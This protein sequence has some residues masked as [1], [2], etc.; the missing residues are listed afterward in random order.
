MEEKSASEVIARLDRIPIWSLSSIFIGILGVGFLFT[1]FDIFDINV[2]FI[3]TALTTFGVTS[4]SSPRIAELLG[5]V[6]LWNL[7]GYVVG[8]LLITPLS[9]RFGR[10]S[11]LVLTMAI[12]GL[13]S[14]YNALSPDYTNYLIARTITGVGVGADLAIVNTY[15]NEVAPIQGRAK[16]TSM[17]FLFA[18]LG[19]FLGLWLGLLLT[20]PPSPFPL[21]LPFALGS[22]GIFTTSGWRI[23]Y[24]IG[25]LLAIIGLALRFELP[26]S[27]RW[28]ISKGRVKEASEIVSRMERMAERKLGSLPPVPQYLE[29]KVATETSY[30]EALK[31]ILGNRVYLR[32]WIVLMLMWFFGYITVYTN[33]AGLTTILSALGYPPPEAGMIAALGV[34]GFIAVPLVLIFLGDKMERKIW[35]PISAAISL[36]GGITLAFSGSN[37]GLAVLG[38]MI[39]FFGIDLWIPISYT[40]TTENFPTRARVTGFGLA[41]GLGHIGGGI[42]A[43]AVALQIGSILSGGVNSSS[44][45][46]VFMLMISFQVISALISLAGI[47]TAKRRLD[48][49]SP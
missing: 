43:F 13:G 49:I 31:T 39:L 46:E 14:L 22:T 11:M 34:L 37:L 26:E 17:V 45:L 42:G 19:A 40:W 23:M 3:Q 25:S 8:A 48:E 10:R 35:V 21:G 38:A 2:S 32:R 30:A 1:F 7:V 36:L 29:V 9:D 47:K 15:I 20:T 41:D 4:P 5:P 27:P 12:T 6:V 24:G 33:A 16:Y 44:S 18:T 28:L